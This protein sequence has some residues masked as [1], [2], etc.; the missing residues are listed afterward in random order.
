MSQNEKT[1]NEKLSELRELVAWFE[2][3][4]FELEEA[5]EKFEQGSELANAIKKDLSEMEN[6]I[7][8]LKEKFNA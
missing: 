6:K 8:V 7:T 1:T 2:N 4:T 5:F 3:D